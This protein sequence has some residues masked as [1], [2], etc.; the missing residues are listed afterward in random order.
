M[1]ICNSRIAPLLDKL[2]KMPRLAEI[3]AIKEKYLFP[4]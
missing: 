4:S 2:G 1:Y 3:Q